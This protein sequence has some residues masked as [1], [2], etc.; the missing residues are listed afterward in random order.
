MSPSLDCIKSGEQ[1]PVPYKL[2]TEKEGEKI[3]TRARRAKVLQAATVSPTASPIQGFRQ[4][5]IRQKAFNKN[6]PTEQSATG[7]LHSFVSGEGN[8]RGTQAG[9][10]D[11]LLHQAPQQ[12]GTRTS[13]FGLCKE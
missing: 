7:S 13:G 4:S 12:G 10:I 6:G 8:P 1:E 2:I 9:G 5:V 11:K 3:T